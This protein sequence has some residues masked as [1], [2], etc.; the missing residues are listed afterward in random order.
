MSLE[1][2]ESSGLEARPWEGRKHGTP[3][4][5]FQS[6]LYSVNMDKAFFPVASISSSVNEVHRWYHDYCRTVG[7]VKEDYICRA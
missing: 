4:P 7:R 6:Q 2:R 5:G 3:Q 1:C